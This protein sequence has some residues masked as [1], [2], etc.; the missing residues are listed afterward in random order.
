MPDAATKAVVTVVA[1]APRYSE[2]V[3]VHYPAGVDRPADRR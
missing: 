3:P 2:K 1:T